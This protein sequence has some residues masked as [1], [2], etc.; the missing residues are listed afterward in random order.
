MSCRLQFGLSDLNTGNI[1]DN[2]RN[3]MS[4]LSLF[5][6]FCSWILD[7]QENESDFLSSFFDLPS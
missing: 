3:V 7:T 4:V 1:A 2:M 5:F 6:F